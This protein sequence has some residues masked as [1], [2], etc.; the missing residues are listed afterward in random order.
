MNAVKIEKL[1][2]DEEVDI[3]DEV[4]EFTS[5]APQKNSNSG[6]LLDIIP[7]S[8]SMHET[9]QGECIASDS[10]E[11]PF[12]KSSGEYLKNLKQDEMETLSGSQIT[13]QTDKPS[14]NDKNQLN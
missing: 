6:L 13:L 12:F 9:N 10:Q 3:T 1:S 14:N 2:D 4:D 11:D 8:S 5:E 7:S